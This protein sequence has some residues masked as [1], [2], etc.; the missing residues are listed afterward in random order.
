MMEFNTMTSDSFFSYNRYFA[1]IFLLLYATHFLGFAPIAGLYPSL[2]SP[3][4]PL[5]LLSFLFAINQKDKKN[6]YS[7]WLILLAIALVGNILSANYFRDMSFFKAFSGQ[8]LVLY[9]FFFFIIAAINPSIEEM[10][11]CM[12]VLGSIGLILYYA[13]YILLPYPIL[14]SVAFGWRSQAEQ[15]DLQRFEVTGEVIIYMYGLYCMNRLLIEFT[16][17]NLLIVLAVL[18]MCVLHGYRGY[19]VAFLFANVYVYFRVSGGKK[20]ILYAAIFAI[21][22]LYAISMLPVFDDVLTFMQEKNVSQSNKNLVEI[23]RVIEFQYF[24]NSYLKSPAEWIFGSGFMGKDEYLNSQAVFQFIN[25]VDLGFLGMSFF[26]GIVMV[27]CWIRLICLNFRKNFE[28]FYFL[29]GLSVYLI[30]G[31][32]IM[33]AAFGAN[34]AVIQ[35]FAF[36]FFYKSHEQYKLLGEN[37]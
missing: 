17:K 19:I 35:A 7:K 6:E 23:D 29:G 15:L 12:E 13:Q 34:S 14:E 20:K 1:L 9:L 11:R 25:W 32:L 10:I 22:V 28:D 27:F 30:L 21:V 36:F 26:G 8:L 3:M 24:F 33:N 37:G 18:S 31:S 16:K 5:L 2:L 4:L